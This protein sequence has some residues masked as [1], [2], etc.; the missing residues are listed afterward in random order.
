MHLRTPK[1][2]QWCV[3]QFVFFL[4]LPH[5]YQARLLQWLSGKE[6]ACNAG[7]T[8]DM[9]LIP[10]LGRYPGGGNGNLLQYACLKNTHGQRSLVGHSPLSHKESDITEAT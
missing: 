1:P 2:T 10:G 8:G 6:S 3:P 7:A 4:F 9:G 5:I